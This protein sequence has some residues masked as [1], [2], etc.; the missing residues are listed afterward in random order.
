MSL[1]VDYSYLLLFSK[2]SRFET[3]G[4]LQVSLAILVYLSEI[5]TRIFYPRHFIHVIYGYLSAFHAG[6]IF[7]ISLYSLDLFTF[8]SLLCFF[9]WSRLYDFSV[10]ADSG[11]DYTTAGEIDMTINTWIHWVFCPRNQYP[12][13]TTSEIFWV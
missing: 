5:S 10:L 11:F 9:H 6:G 13:G 4:C 7:R 8:M 3:S 12:A 2:R 1:Y